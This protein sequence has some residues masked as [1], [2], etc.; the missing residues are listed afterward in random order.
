MRSRIST[1]GRTWT[2]CSAPATKRR[3]CTVRPG[4]FSAFP[5]DDRS[6]HLR[7]NR[8]VDL[9]C[10]EPGHHERLFAERREL[11]RLV[12]VRRTWCVG[13]E[14][15]IHVVEVDPVHPLALVDDQ[16]LPPRGGRTPCHRPPE[17]VRA[18]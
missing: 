6:G 10:P 9:R 15:V 16:R 11:V 13:N 8:A 18:C 7:M 14:R 12:E 17:K 2:T 5:D 3:A 4:K 1:P